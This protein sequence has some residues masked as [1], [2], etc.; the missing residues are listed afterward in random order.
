MGSCILKVKSGLKNCGTSF[1][2]KLKKVLSS[3]ISHGKT[4]DMKEQ[5]TEQNCHLISL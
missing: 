2:A 5:F 3:I 1:S 4:T